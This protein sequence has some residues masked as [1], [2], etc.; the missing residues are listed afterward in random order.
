M[1]KSWIALAVA[2]ALAVGCGPS[3]EQKKVEKSAARQQEWAAIETAKKELDAKRKEL[4]A[5]RVQSTAGVDVKAQLDAT[6]TLVTKLTNA[7]SARLAD[8]INA[9][10]P[11][12]GEPLRPDQLAAVRINSSEGIAV[13]REYVELGGDYRKA[14]DIYNQLL[15]ADPDNADVKAAKAQAESL[16]FMNPTRFASVKKGMTDGEVI[17]AIGR[18]LG[19]NIKEYPDKKVTAWFYP[20]NE[21]G[22]AA[23]IFFHEK[24]GKKTAYEM[25]YDAVKTRSVGEAPETK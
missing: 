1:R 23:G 25:K 22:D 5:L 17:A 10:P 18:P 6:D 21:E 24:D 9:D 19:R 12:Q 7:F 11:I 8:Y 13:A 15:Q 14:I 20:K 3:E 16:R 4:Y 2:A